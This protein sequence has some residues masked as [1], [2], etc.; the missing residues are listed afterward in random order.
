M[1]R[2]GKRAAVAPTENGKK[3]LD[4]VAYP[5]N[6]LG[7][8]ER[9]V[10]LRQTQH[11][12]AVAL[13]RVRERGVRLHDALRA[14]RRPPAEQPEGGVVPVGRVGFQR[15]GLGAQPFLEGGVVHHKRL[16]GSGGILA[17]RDAGLMRRFGRR[18][19]GH[20]LAEGVR[21]AGIHKK[22]GAAR[23]AEEVRDLVAPKVR[24]Q[25]DAHGADPQRAEEGGDEIRSVRER[26]EDPLLR[27][28][29][30]AAQEV[31]V[32]VRERGRPRRRSSRHRR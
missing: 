21:A 17:P 25:H 12:L 30:G 11:P 20:P 13:R 29:A 28:H 16:A 2:S 27:S 15:R 10:V 3:R 7:D 22:D 18:R 23:I 19:R 31:A 5:K 6:S 4:P 32:A 8:G 26:D 9:D 1:Q 14:S 24:V